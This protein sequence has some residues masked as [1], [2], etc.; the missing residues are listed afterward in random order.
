M[1]V[2]VSM[3][4][5]QWMGLIVFMRSVVVVLTCVVQQQHAYAVRHKLCR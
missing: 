5:A 2:V 1:M 3:S 4:G